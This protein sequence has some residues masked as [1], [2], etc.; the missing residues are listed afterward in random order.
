[1]ERVLGAGVLVSVSV[2][3][4]KYYYTNYINMHCPQLAKASRGWDFPVG[5]FSMEIRFLMFRTSFR[6]LG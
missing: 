6:P 5:T 2:L 1:M 4:M 3:F